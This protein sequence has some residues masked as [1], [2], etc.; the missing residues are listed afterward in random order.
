MKW[1]SILLKRTL[2]GAVMF[3]LPIVIVIFI[4][5]KA[6][7]IV[8]GLTSPLKESLADASVLGV[9]VLT[10]LSIFFV[11]ALCYFAGRR[12]EQK[13]LKSYLPFLE[14]NLLV[15]IPGYSLLK[16]SAN[17]AMGETEVEWKV[18]LLPDGDGWKFGIEVERD[19]NG[20][21]TVF[22]PEPPDAKSGEMKLVPSSTLR[23][24]DIPVSKLFSI[25]RKYGHGSSI[26][27][28]EN[29]TI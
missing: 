27:Q 8:R 18:V 13:K 28:R 26:F 25:I 16:S 22:F 24:S 11:L 4:V 7:L 1:Y 6:I 9:G 19:I 21:S 14:E 12:A 20:N 3:L 10:L 15:F 23:T 29:P 2:K 5:E 17:Q